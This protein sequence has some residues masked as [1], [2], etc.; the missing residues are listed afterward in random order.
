MVQL[1]EIETAARRIAGKVHRTPTVTASNLGQMVGARLLLKAELLQKT[2]SFKVRGV[3]NKL[4]TLPSEELQRGLITLSAGNHGQALAWGAATAGTSATVVMPATAVKSKVEAIRGYGGE[5][6]QTSGNL[7]EECLALRDRR[8]LT[9]VHPF[10]DP[11]V[12]AGQGTVGLEIL[13]DVADAEIV[14]VPI[15]GG[16]LI[17]GVAAAIKQ[18]RPGVRVIGVEPI[19]SDVMTRSLSAGEPVR[20]ERSSTIADGLAAPFAGVQTLAHV[21]RFVDQVV[22]VDDAA[23]LRALRLIME[24]TK[25]MAEPAG[26]AAFAAVLTGAFPVPASTRVVCVVSGGNAD[27]AV[28]QRALQL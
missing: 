26:A 18:C 1:S 22:L 28:L 3:L 5:V 21:R 2:G 17:A 25:L 14:V 12:I 4:L 10:D 6:I 23:I 11:A 16:G 19:G 9:L 15:G 27:P 8:G 20:M 24:R 13:Q 7:L